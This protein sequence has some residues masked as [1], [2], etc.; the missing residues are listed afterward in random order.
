MLVRMFV[1]LALVFAI[2]AAPAA[3]RTHDVT[4]DDY[5]SLATITEM[6]R[7]SSSDREMTNDEA[8]MTNQ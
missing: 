3:E 4:P 8:R 2:P 1:L 7:R 5:F 6:L